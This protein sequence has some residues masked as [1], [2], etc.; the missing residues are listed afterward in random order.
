[1]DVDA[2]IEVL[3]SHPSRTVFLV[4]FDGSLA[5]MVERAED[6]RP[7]PAVV[8]LLER[9]ATRVGRV[10]IVSGRPVGF[11]AAYVGARGVT[12]TGLYGMEHVV[13][14]QRRVDPRVEPYLAT[15]AAAQDE[16]LA[17]LPVELVEPKSGVCVTVHWRPRPD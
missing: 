5:P 1:M 17:R 8:D 2:T 12:L 9:L 14:G 4:D 13:D 16:L 6:A 3:T 11:L 10:G 7:L 15:I